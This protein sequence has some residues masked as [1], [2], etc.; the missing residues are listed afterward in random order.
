M[1]EVPITPE[2]KGENFPPS[3]T[4]DSNFL[5]DSFDDN[6]FEFAQG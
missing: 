4:R 2:Q 5:K 1:P 3:E 6:P